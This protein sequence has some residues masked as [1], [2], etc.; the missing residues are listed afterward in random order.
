MTIEIHKTE[1]E[2]LFLERMKSG[3]IIGPAQTSFA[4]LQAPPWREI[5]I[6]PARYRLPARDISM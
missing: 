3:G 6:E 4:A 2:A 5:N 1:L